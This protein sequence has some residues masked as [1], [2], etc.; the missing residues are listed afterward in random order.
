M[1]F[2]IVTFL[3]LISTL[4]MG[5]TCIHVL[6]NDINVTVI[7]N[8]Q[9]TTLS[10]AADHHNVSVMIQN[11]GDTTA[12]SLT[13]DAYYCSKNIGIPCVNRTINVGDLPPN[14][15][16]VEYFEYDRDAFINA[17]EGAY[18]LKLQYVAESCNS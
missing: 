8:T 5:C 6:N 10:G 4:T 3:L 2:L 17:G 12:K 13:I 11:T 1:K 14:G 15:A 9:T 18:P 16:I 7:Q